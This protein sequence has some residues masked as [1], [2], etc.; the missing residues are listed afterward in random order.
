MLSCVGGM[1]P[2]F[3]AAFAREYGRALFSSAIAALLSLPDSLFRGV[4]MD[5]IHALFR[6]S[7]QL[8]SAGFDAAHTVA[9]CEVAALDITLRLFNSSVLAQRVTGMKLLSA[10][11][12]AVRLDTTCALNAHALLAWIDHT[13]M[14]ERIFIADVPVTRALQAHHAP[15]ARADAYAL[16]P[17]LRAAFPPALPAAEATFPYLRARVQ[18]DEPLSPP[19]PELMRR[20]D[21]VIRLMVRAHIFPPVIVQLLL[22]TAAGHSQEHIAAVGK[23]RT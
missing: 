23:V 1:A 11:A 16:P 12:T 7:L 22:R 5:H 8:L 13:G 17:A 9:A 21:D 18:V 4:D 3:G 2:F 10:A 6:S 20:L 15:D 14:L 19:H